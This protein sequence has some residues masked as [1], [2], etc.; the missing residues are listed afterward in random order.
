M[1]HKDIIP[2]TA[3]EKASI[4]E[5]FNRSKNGTLAEL[6]KTIE[7]EVLG[8]ALRKNNFNMSKTAEKVGINRATLRSKAIAL[9]ITESGY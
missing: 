3:E 8:T 9:N 7:K 2:L 5:I 6:I 1:S 4:K